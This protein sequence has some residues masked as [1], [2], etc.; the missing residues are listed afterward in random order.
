[1]TYDVIVV[2]ARCTGAPL[3]MVLSRAGH[4]V[5]LLDRGRFPSDTMST[6]W[7]L[8]PGVELLAQWGLLPAL[9]RTGCPPIERMSMDFGG[10]ELSGAPTGPHGVAV[11]YAPRRVVLDQLLVDAARD[12][13]ARLR[14]GFAVRDVIREDGRVCG[15]VGPDGETARARLVIGADGRNST[16]A[17][18][19][20]ARITEDCGVLAATAYGYWSGLPVSEVRTGFQPGLGVS[21]WPTHDGLTVVSTTMRRA[22]FLARGRDGARRTYLDALA[23]SGVADLVG[24]GRLAGRVLSATNLRNF[25]RQS[26]GP[27]W[28]LAGDAGHHKDPIAA[29]GISDAFTDAHTLAAA[30]HDGLTG[31]MDMDRALA[32]YQARRNAGRSAMFD[33][34]CRQAMLEPV[35]G[36]LARLLT[37]LGSNERAAR[38][39]LG[40]FAGA[41]RLEEFF[42]PANIAGLMAASA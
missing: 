9:V 16:I 17:R 4:S 20:G 32:R 40:V 3:A 11:T 42:A 8:R 36:E 35:D 28:A 26:H 30:V 39:M 21:L 13:G 38:D 14:E 23:R 25:H 33:F 31:A 12:A 41:R 29:R 27:G 5:L 15:V 1:M 6:H 19:V 10:C 18:A 34:T 2:G 37:V 24:T 22:H 7:V